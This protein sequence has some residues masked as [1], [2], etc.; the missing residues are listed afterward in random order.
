MKSHWHDYLFK[1]CLGYAA[2]I[3]EFL[4]PFKTQFI[5]NKCK[6][7]EDLNK[8]QLICNK[9]FP[10]ESVPLGKC[11]FSDVGSLARGWSSSNSSEMF[12]K[13]KISS[14]KGGGINIAS[15]LYLHCGDIGSNIYESSAAET[16]K[17]KISGDYKTR[18]SQWGGRDIG[19]ILKVV[20]IGVAQSYGKIKKINDSNNFSLPACIL[21][22]RPHSRSEGKVSYKWSINSF[23][24]F[25]PHNTILHQQHANL[26]EVKEMEY[27]RHSEA[28]THVGRLIM[29]LC[30]S[31]RQTDGFCYR[32][33]N[34]EGNI[35]AEKQ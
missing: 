3:W 16:T 20:I 30:C 10:A 4:H 21:E 22:Q 23:Y 14:C 15:K 6:T 8:P 12:T 11:L 26:L 28:Q 13:Y 32:T 34:S 35:I 27:N 24:T 17:R 19:K 5:I 1:I 7:H 9:T 25:L 2:P 18:I 33:V 31:Q 29:V